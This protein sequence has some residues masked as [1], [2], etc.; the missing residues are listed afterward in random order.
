MRPSK[1]ISDESGDLFRARLVQIINLKHEP[2]QLG[3]R[4]PKPLRVFL[5]DQRHGVHGQNKRELRR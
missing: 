3:Q 4:A 1:K 5:S 2:V